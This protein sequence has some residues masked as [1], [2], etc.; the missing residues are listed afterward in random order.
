[1]CPAAMLADAGLFVEH[2]AKAATCIR[3]GDHEASVDCSEAELQCYI[4]LILVNCCVHATIHLLKG[5][6]P[7]AQS[8]QNSRGCT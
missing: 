8:Q 7:H 6:Q 1:M 5:T 3:C 2:A 4:N